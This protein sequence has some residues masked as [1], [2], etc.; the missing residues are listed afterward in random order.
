MSWMFHDDTVYVLAD[1]SLGISD[2]VGSA[3]EEWVSPQSRAPPV[4]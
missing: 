2:S 3:M 4:L 1:I